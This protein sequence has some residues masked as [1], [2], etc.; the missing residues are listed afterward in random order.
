MN[1]FDQALTSLLRETYLGT[2]F[3]LTHIPSVITCAYSIYVFLFVMFMY[4]Y[5]YYIIT[6]V[7]YVYIYKLQTL[8]V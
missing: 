1:S 3:A 8:Y 2:S 4:V 6:Y 5:L 7:L